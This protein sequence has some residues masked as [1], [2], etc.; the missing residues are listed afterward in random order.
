[1]SDRVVS[2]S[3]LTDYLKAL[4]EG[5]PLLADIWVEG[6]VSNVFASQ[7]GHTYFTL[8]D[9]PS[10][11]ECVLFGRSAARQRHPLRLG[12]HVAVHGHMGIYERRGQYQLVADVVQPAGLGLLWLQLEQLR[13]KLEAEGLF[14]ESRKRPLPTPPRSIGVVTSAQGAVWHDIQQVARRRYPFVELILAPA[15]VQGDA[16]PAS[17]VRSIEALQRVE[18]VDLIIVARG[19]GSVEDLWCFN[20]ERVVRAIFASR[21]PVVAGIGHETDN[22]LADDVADLR[23]P[24]PSAAAEICLPSVAEAAQRILELASRAQH[25]ATFALHHRRQVLSLFDRRLRRLTPTREIERM[26]SSVAALEARLR[27][28]TNRDVSAHQGDLQ[29]LRD[30]LVTLEPQAMLNRGYALLSHPSSGH[31]VSKTSSVRPGE[32][33][34]AELSN[35]RLLVDVRETLPGA[36][37]LSTA[38][39][40]PDRAKAKVNA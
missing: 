28:V 2:V 39:Q 38:R 20:D 10:Q 19:G 7:A 6:E 9:H 5:D 16:A 18:R 26:R 8:R 4:F 22:T 37:E 29:R 11:L 30:L 35:G 32:T 1:V 36:Q 15:S 3:A 24:T 23:A 12:D 31:P 25:S 21:V 14:D 34:R 33:L 40:A 17:I 13:Q 27:L